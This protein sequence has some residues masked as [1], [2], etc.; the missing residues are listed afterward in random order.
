VKAIDEA[1]VGETMHADSGVDAGYPEAA[2]LAF[3]LP[4]MLIRI[5]EAVDE[6]FAGPFD[7]A[8]TDTSM[9]PRLSDHFLVSSPPGNASLDP[10]QILSPL[11]S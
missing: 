10:A 5:I 4:A 8:V 1:I 9:T 11:H 7:K 3:A 2:K 6:R